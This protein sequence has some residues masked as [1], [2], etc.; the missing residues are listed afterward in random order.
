MLA[1]RGVAPAG[2]EVSGVDMA[3]DAE[4]DLAVEA[5]IASPLSA[6]A[7]IAAATRTIRNR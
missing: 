1:G 7:A 4:G 5:R 3:P 6:G 2:S